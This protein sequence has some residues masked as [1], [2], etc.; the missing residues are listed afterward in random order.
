MKLLK[1]LFLL[2]IFLVPLMSF[3]QLPSSVKW[4][5]VDRY[6]QQADK[7][8]FQAL[9][10][11]VVLLYSSL[12]E[13]GEEEQLKKSTFL[14]N[15]LISSAI[16][17]DRERCFY[18]GWISVKI[19]GECQAPWRIRSDEQIN[20]A[21]PGHIYTREHT[22]GPND[23][24][25]CNPILFGEGADGAKCVKIDPREKITQ[26]CYEASAELLPNHLQNIANDPTLRAQYAT[27][28][29]EVVTHCREKNNHSCHNMAK[30]IDWII[31]TPVIGDNF[32]E[33]CLNDLKET[34]G[35]Y[36]GLEEI[37][38]MV[39][40]KPPKIPGIW[41]PDTDLSDEG[42]CNISGLT[43]DQKAKCVELLGN[44]DVPRDAL[45]FTLDGIRRNADE[46]KTNQCFDQSSGYDKQFSNK[47][48]SLGGMDEPSD[49]TK[50]MEKGIKNKCRFI[51]NDVG[52]PQESHGGELK[53]LMTTYVVNI[54][55]GESRKTKAW[56]GYGTCKRGRGNKNVTEQGTTLLGFHVANDTSVAFAKNDKSYN[57]IRDR[58][59][60]Y[61]RNN[62]GEV[63]QVTRNG[64]K[65]NV[66][67]DQYGNRANRVPTLAL[68]GLQHTNNRSMQDYKYLHIGAYT[69]AGCPSLVES[70]ENYKLIEEL[71]RDGPS[72]IVNYKEGQMDDYEKCE[73]RDE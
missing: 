33:S 56:L 36:S 50:K 24:M 63:R 27:M 29:E 31:N 19:G 15:L 58:Y 2:L 60:E 54:C 70:P 17:D 65:V 20:E 71:G 52:D 9:H 10:K 73:K 45:L 32:L 57:D 49:F 25:R 14:W 39:L 66:V 47:H 68:F 4:K 22:C 72:V 55:T 34:I 18:G 3:A 42:A 21:F 40:T 16:A 28:V 44:G 46:F 13:E 35:D 30:S 1:N 48:Y 38:R 69:S 23:V 8:D 61:W 59:S 41:E 7:K 53:C 62:G 11:H 37:N 67:Y 64:R 12:D 6:I 26:K 5:Q 51:I 43:A